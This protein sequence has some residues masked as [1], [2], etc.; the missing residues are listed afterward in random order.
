MAIPEDITLRPAFAAVAATGLD[1]T[2]LI[3]VT[4][5]VVQVPRLL[6]PIDVQGLRV[7]KLDEIEHADIATTPILDAATSEGTDPADHDATA[8]SPFSD[9]RPR[10]PGVYVHWAVPDALTRGVVSVDDEEE[11]RASSDVEFP[12][13]PNR[14]CVTRFWWVGT[15]Y[16]TRSWIVESDRGRIV[17]LEDWTEDESLPTEADADTPGIEPAD[18]TAVMG[19]D[20]AW[21]TVYDN[22]EN[23]FA[24]RDDLNDIRGFAGRV[25]YA[26]AGWYS[27]PELDP[28]AGTRLLS[29]FQNALEELR[30]SADLSSLSSAFSVTDALTSQIGQLTGDPEAGATDIVLDRSELNQASASVMAGAGE[31]VKLP[32]PNWPQQ[33]IYHGTLYAVPLSGAGLDPKP[34]PDAVE[35]GIGATSSEALSSLMAEAVNEQEEGA[36]EQLLN[37]LQYGV[38]ADLE[39]P[40]GPAKLGEEAHRRAF[41]SQPGGFTQERIRAG[42]PFAHLRT[43]AGQLPKPPYLRAELEQARLLADKEIVFEF[44]ATDRHGLTGLHD[45]IQPTQPVKEIDTVSNVRGAGS[46]PGGSVLEPLPFIAPNVAAL[47]ADETPD[48]MRAVSNEFVRPGDP[49]LRPR[50]DKGVEYRTVRRALPR[51]FQAQD[52]VA[53]LRGVGRTIRHH[54]DDRYDEDGRLTCRLSTSETRDI[55]GVIPGRHLLENQLFAASIPSDVQDLLDEAAL[56]T[57]GA[58]DRLVAVAASRAQ[59][60]GMEDALRARLAAEDRLFVNYLVPGT[61]AHELANAS[62]KAGTLPSPKAITLWHQAWEPMYLEWELDVDLLTD[63]EQWRLAE[64]DIDPVTPLPGDDESTLVSGRALL[65]RAAA[66]SISELIADFIDQEENLDNGEHTTGVLGDAA[67]ADLRIL[68]ED[69]GDADILH[70]SFDGLRDWLLGFDTN[71][72]YTEAHTEGEI[73]PDRLPE[74]LRAGRATV[75]R[76]R[77]VDAFG[78]FVDLRPPFSFADD[79]EVRAEDGDDP[80]TFLLRPRITAPTRLWFRFVDATDDTKDAIVDQETKTLQR[81]PVAGWL[82]PDHVDAAL[83][84]FDAGGEPLGQ[85]RNERLGSGVV[86]EGAPGRPGPMGRPPFMDVANPHTAELA[87][88]MI[89]RDAAERQAN[90]EQKESTLD[91]L[92]RAVDT[93]LWTVDPFADS[94]LD[95]YA[96]MTGRPIAVVRARLLLDVVS[97]FELFAEDDP[98]R[99]QRKAK[100]DELSQRSFEVR[101]GALTKIDDGLLGYF[102]NDD[103]WRF[104][105]VHESVREEALASGPHRGFLGT[106]AEVE[107]FAE[108]QPVEKITHPYVVPDPTVRVQPGHPV[109]LTLLLDPGTRVHATS[110]IVPRKAISLPRAFVEEALARIAPSFRFGPVLVDPG[111]IRMPKPSVLPEDQVWTRRDTPTSWRDDPIEV[112]TQFAYLPDISHE[113]QEGYIRVRLDP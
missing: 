92:L 31:I 74:L 13:L 103:Y 53:S 19:G 55:P 23:R 98:R 84:L 71:V 72:R 73:L 6:V 56:N 87:R 109:K 47:S 50:P 41:E 62:M 65:S 29:G 70:A 82:L 81:N 35:V 88:A 30:W 110:G 80:D 104:H 40:D 61:S 105:P 91:A 51:L 34:T 101:L 24:F 106:L 58:V 77:V 95:Y 78:R 11:L 94:G 25:N 66:T 4:D 102:V 7:T 75:T 52:P 54:S 20:A 93:T 26:V 42:D 46:G 85:L 27:V 111:V 67:L 79:I 5:T 60:V 15:S 112:A 113:A 69:A 1:A 100:Y 33:S 89:E 32:K 48:Y 59:T 8:P 16:R 10:E 43:P 12:P 39:T 64:L 22:V 45:Q 18:L 83:E 2:S 107:K 17:A 68:N 37:A 44:V 49:T 28:I 38:I 63:R 57:P 99:T 86:W 90:T 76:L 9:L 36:R 21:F 14:W 96:K 3:A 108:N 97:D